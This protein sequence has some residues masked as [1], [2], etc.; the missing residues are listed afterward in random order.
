MCTSTYRKLFSISLSFH[1]VL[2]IKFCHI[3]FRNLIQV[4]WYVLKSIFRLFE[5][6]SILLLFKAMSDKV[7]VQQKCK[8]A[9][10]NSDVEIRNQYSRVRFRLDYNAKTHLMSF[11]EQDPNFRARIDHL[12][13]YLVISQRKH[14][15]CIPF[16]QLFNG[17]AGTEINDESRGLKGKKQV[18]TTYLVEFLQKL[19][20]WFTCQV[21]FLAL[22]ILTL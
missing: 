20:L 12:F 19:F 14:Y 9:I 3:L 7:F 8:K 2:Y 5:L 18:G 17:N 13:F 4:L 16:A 22:I 10:R 21:L 11:S 6:C 1:T 15:L